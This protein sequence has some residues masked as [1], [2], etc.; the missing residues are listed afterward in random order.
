MRQ[1]ILQK[2]LP[3]VLGKIN[4]LLYL[5]DELTNDFESD[6]NALISF[7]ASIDLT[8]FTRDT[9]KQIEVLIQRIMIQIMLKGDIVKLDAF[10][11]AMNENTLPLLFSESNCTRIL[12][13]ERSM[14]N[15]YNM[16]LHTIIEI[17]SNRVQEHPRTA[18]INSVVKAAGIPVSPQLMDLMLMSQDSH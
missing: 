16:Y 13:S 18:F 2:A 11:N 9:T 4:A 3:Q 5:S 1:V 14:T 7:T 12:Q 8:K 17:R 6:L 10:R 15:L